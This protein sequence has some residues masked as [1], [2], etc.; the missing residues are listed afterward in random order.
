[1]NKSESIKEI[2]TAL[3]KVQAA[4]APAKKDS[5]NPFFNS[6]YADLNSVWDACRI[7]LSSNGLS[8]TQLNQVSDSGVIVETVLMH[9]SGEWI[10]G[11][12]L[13]PL[14]KQNAQG[15]GSAIT[16]GRRYGLA[17]II[18]IVADEDDDGNKASQKQFKQPPSKSN[19]NGTDDVQLEAIATVARNK[20]VDANEISAEMFEGKK[21][22]ELSFDQKSKLIRKL[23]VIK[24]GK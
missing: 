4:M 18:G 11:E 10:S 8:V 12:I 22:S 7:L 23:N 6:N 3:A 14:D 9:S 1:M 13:L 16:Y 24:A 17:A 15:V 5:K 19:K 21:P 20:S 2:A